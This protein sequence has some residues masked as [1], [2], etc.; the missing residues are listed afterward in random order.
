MNPYLNILICITCLKEWGIGK[1]ALKY[2]IEQCKV[3][4]YLKLGEYPETVDDD[5]KYPMCL[6]SLAF[7]ASGMIVSESLDRDSTDFNLGVNPSMSYEFRKFSISCL[8]HAL[9]R[10]FGC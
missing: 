5:F 6:E 2:R 10:K 8:W 9:F 1:T 4:V 7:H 3:A